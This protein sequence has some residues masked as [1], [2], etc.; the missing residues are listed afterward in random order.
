[1]H[2]KIYVEL[3]REKKKGGTWFFAW[4]KILENRDII[5]VVHYVLLTVRN[6]LG[7]QIVLGN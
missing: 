4:M 1:M 5:E 7:V 6:C 3:W 2:D